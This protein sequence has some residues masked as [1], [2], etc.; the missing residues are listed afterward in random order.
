MRQSNKRGTRIVDRLQMC[1]LCARQHRSASARTQKRPAAQTHNTHLRCSNLSVSNAR[2]ESSLDA[3]RERPK[4][5]LEPTGAL[6]CLELGDAAPNEPFFG[7][8]L[9]SPADE[10]TRAL[11]VTCGEL[12]HRRISELRAKWQTTFTRDCCLLS[13]RHRLCTRCRSRRAPFERRMLVQ[14]RSFAPRSSP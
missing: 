12:L 6:D 2:A 3:T 4:S 14:V 1:S 8:L 5:T 13:A 11:L 7:F 9:S 10:S